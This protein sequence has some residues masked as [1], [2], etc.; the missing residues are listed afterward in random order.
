M[1]QFA[2][3][4][5]QASLLQ[6]AELIYGQPVQQLQLSATLRRRAHTV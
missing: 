5:Q 6:V 4:D 3:A 1:Q 2:Q